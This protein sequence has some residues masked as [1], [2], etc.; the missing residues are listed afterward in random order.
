MRCERIFAHQNVRT[1]LR[2]VAVIDVQADVGR[3]G[4]IRG[5]FHISIRDRGVAVVAHPDHRCPAPFA[6]RVRRARLD[7]YHRLWE[8]GAQLQV[9]LQ[10]QPQPRRDS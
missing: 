9:H 10:L 3:R 8:W 5:V 4:G 2:S 6:E 7:L 1:L